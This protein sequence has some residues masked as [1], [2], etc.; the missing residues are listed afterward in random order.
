MSSEEARQIVENGLEK[1]KAEM[2]RRDAELEDQARQLR[3]TIS[4][5]H[6]EKTMTE[7]QKKARAEEE[8]RR[9]KAERAQAK[10]ARVYRDMK[11]E[12]AV[13]RYGIV[14]LV[15]L[16]LTAVTRLNIFVMIALVLG[17]AVFP[18]ADIYR[19]YNPI[20]ENAN[21]RVQR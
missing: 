11:A 21:D 14:C 5:N 15:I 10:A 7:I 12:E 13:N 17:L 3:M 18:I 4:G 20:Q 9:R 2:V 1:R 19:L 16:L 6:V 8:A